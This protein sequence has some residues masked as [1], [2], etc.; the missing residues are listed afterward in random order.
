MKSLMDEVVDELVR[1][2][3]EG[4]IS[5]TLLSYFTES[6]AALVTNLLVDQIVDRD[7]LSELVL[8]VMHVVTCLNVFY[9]CR[10]LKL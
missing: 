6:Q 10:Q 3:V 1:D 7:Y 4:Y 9:C 2:E 5:N 8:C